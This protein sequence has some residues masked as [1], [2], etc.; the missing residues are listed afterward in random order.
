MQIYA[1]VN[2]L[3]CWI[4]VSRLSQTFRYILVTISTF[5]DVLKVAFVDSN[6]DI[7]RKSL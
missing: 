6:G 4:S 7:V 1:I 2:V 3:F 5:S